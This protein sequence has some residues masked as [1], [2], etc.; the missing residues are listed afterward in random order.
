MH[1]Y[2]VVV[3][4]V[5]NRSWTVCLHHRRKHSHSRSWRR[6][7]V[8]ALRSVEDIVVG[9]LTAIAAVVVGMKGRGRE[10]ERRGSMGSTW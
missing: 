4:V 10:G 2:A 1:T 6:M 5:E 3:V 9:V 8:S 7:C